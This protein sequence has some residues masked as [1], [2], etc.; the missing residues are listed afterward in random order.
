MKQSRAAI[1]GSAYPQALTLTNPRF[2]KHWGTKGPSTCISW[3]WRRTSQK[4]LAK[5]NF[6]FLIV[7]R[8]ERHVS[9]PGLS[10][11]FFISDSK[12]QTILYISIVFLR[13]GFHFFVLRV[14]F[15]LVSHFSQSFYS[16]P[17]PSIW[18]KFAFY[19]YWK[20]FVSATFVVFGFIEII[21]A[22]DG[23]ISRQW[24]GVCW[25]SSKK[26]LRSTQVT[27]SSVICF[28]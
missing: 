9:S 2:G 21:S 15:H 14:F 19:Y 10:Y 4:N 28:N 23:I 17:I 7:V 24:L 16:F 22:S 3:R 26:Y 6:H 20:N 13:L 5:S 12:K 27:V 8:R 25:S 18:I 1:H 11:S